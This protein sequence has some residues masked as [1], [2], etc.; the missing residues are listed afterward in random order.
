L[1]LSR[2]TRTKDAPAETQYFREKFRFKFKLLAADR[3]LQ[4][5][6][7]TLKF[8]PPQLRWKDGINLEE[9]QS[10]HERPVD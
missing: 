4:Q 6:Q 8:V 7:S 1:R 9:V 2:S 5:S 10:D 3:D